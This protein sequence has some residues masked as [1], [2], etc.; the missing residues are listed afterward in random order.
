[1]AGIWLVRHARSAL[2][3]ICY[4]QSNVPVTL[5]PGEAARLLA[6]LWEQKGACAPE[7]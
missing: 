1:M 4:G 2:S 5:E 3:G 7:L 6:E